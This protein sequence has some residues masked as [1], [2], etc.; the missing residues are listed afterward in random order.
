MVHVDTDE[1]IVIHSQ[2]RQ[3]NHWRNLSLSTTTTTAENNDKKTKRWNDFI[4]LQKPSSILRFIKRAANTYSKAVS[5][6]CISMPRLLFGSV[7]DNDNIENDKQMKEENIYPPM[8]FAKSKFE[9]LRWKYHSDYDND[10][11]LNGRPK[12]ILDL[13]GLPPRAN[14]LM[15]PMGVFSI[16]RPGLFL[17]RSDRGV[18][19]EQKHKFPITVNH[20]LGS[21]ERYN[22]RSDARRSRTVRY[23]SI[24]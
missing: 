12:V 6:P 16:H 9:T 7:E 5:Y 22:Q 3:Q 2:V 15:K 21:W 20:Y 13:S 19:F 17:C 24:N 8:P 10:F 4:G 18:V 11:S 1:Y 14:F 23:L